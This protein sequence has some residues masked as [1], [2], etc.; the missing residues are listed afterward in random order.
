M[1]QAIL[2]RHSFETFGTMRVYP[3]REEETDRTAVDQVLGFTKDTYSNFSHYVEFRPD[4]PL[5]VLTYKL[6][7]R[8]LGL[9]LMIILSPFLVIGL[10]I[11]F[12]AVL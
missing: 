2:I 4:D 12:M 3:N 5:W 9:I 11:A 7:L 6:I 8:F 1:V 10:T